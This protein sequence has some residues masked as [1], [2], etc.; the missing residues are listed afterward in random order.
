MEKPYTQS[1]DAKVSHCNIL[2]KFTFTGSPDLLS[3]C[4]PGWAKAKTTY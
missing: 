1:K 3:L 2:D 4:I